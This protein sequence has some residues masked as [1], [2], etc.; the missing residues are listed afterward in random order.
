MKPVVAYRHKLS[1]R[2]WWAWS[3]ARSAVLKVAPLVLLGIGLVLLIAAG[4]AMSLR[5]VIRPGQVL[6]TGQVITA[7]Q[8][9]PVAVVRLDSGIVV[10]LES[11]MLADCRHGDRIRV[12]ETRIIGRGHS[13]TRLKS[14]PAGGCRRPLP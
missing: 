11:P 9:I 8:P 2:L 13:Y 6:A 3:A 10:R 1:W 14:R 12:I 7:S 4:F 5:E